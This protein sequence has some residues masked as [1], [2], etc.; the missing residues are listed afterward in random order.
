[1][2]NP[3]SQPHEQIPSL[4]LVLKTLKPSRPC[5]CGPSGQTRRTDST[6]PPTGHC[7]PGNR[8]AGARSC[9]SGG[10]FWIHGCLRGS[11][12][13]DGRCYRSCGTWEAGLLPGNRDGCGQHCRSCGTRGRPRDSHAS[14]GRTCHIQS[15]MRPGCSQNHPQQPGQG[16][17]GNHGAGGQC[18]HSCGTCERLLRLPSV[19]A[20]QK[21]LVSTRRKEGRGAVQWT[22]PVSQHW[23]RE[24]GHGFFLPLLLPLSFPSAKR[25]IEVMI[26]SL[27]LLIPSTSGAPQREVFI[28]RG[29]KAKNLGSGDRDTNPSMIKSKLS[30]SGSGRGDICVIGQRIGASTV[31]FSPSQQSSPTH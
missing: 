13:A 31:S 15:R 27:P 28:S 24:T 8:G 12:D 21:P 25:R 20:N 17:R 10:T 6:C 5:S 22:R 16:L 30:G 19:G 23:R 26:G 11:H 3:A 9:R 4:L 7:L 2:R 1:M 18:C 14:S 29:R